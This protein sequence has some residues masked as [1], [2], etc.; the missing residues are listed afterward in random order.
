MT[1][2]LPTEE[3][4]PRLIIRFV[5][6]LPTGSGDVVC[7]R[8]AAAAA[9]EEREALEGRRWPNAAPAAAEAAAA[10]LRST[11]YIG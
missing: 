6:R 11:G 8:N 4:D 2:P 9:A 10:V 1:L 3:T 5:W 7:E